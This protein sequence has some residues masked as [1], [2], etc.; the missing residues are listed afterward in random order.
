MKAFMKKFLKYFVFDF[1]ETWTSFKFKNFYSI[2][3]FTYADTVSKA[4]LSVNFARVAPLSRGFDKAPRQE[5]TPTVKKNL[6][7]IS[8][9]KFQS[10]AVRF[11][12][13]ITFLKEVTNLKLKLNLKVNIDFDV[14]KNCSNFHC[15]KLLTLAPVLLTLQIYFT[16]FIWFFHTDFKVYCPCDRSSAEV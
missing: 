2:F 15:L 6:G 14:W 12:T 7:E 1:E 8:G 11:N 3:K 5:I 4:F 16:C 10:L 13:N 9:C